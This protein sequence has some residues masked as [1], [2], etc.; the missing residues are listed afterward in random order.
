MTLG[1]GS[2]WAGPTSTSLRIPRIVRVIGAHVIAVRLPSAASRV[3]THTGRR[4]DGGPRSAQNTS[5]RATTPGRFVRPTVPP[6]RRTLGLVEFGDRHPA[7]AGLLGRAR[8]PQARPRRRDGEVRID[9]CLPQRRLG[10]AV[11]PGRHRVGPVPLVAPCTYGTAY[12]LRLAAIGSRGDVGRLRCLRGNGGRPCGS[13]RNGWRQFVHRRDISRG[14][15]GTAA[16]STD[17]DR[18]PAQGLRRPMATVR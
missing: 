6:T 1:S 3:S 4:P 16:A 5:P 8:W 15:H 14:I 12:G 17:H 7:V 10:R 9:W 13:T 18:G 2:P 11:P